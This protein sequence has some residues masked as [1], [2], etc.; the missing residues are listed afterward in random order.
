MF[1]EYLRGKG[2]YAI[3]ES[4]TRDEHAQSKSAVRTILRNPRYTGPE[5][6]KI[7]RTGPSQVWC[8]LDQS[9][10]GQPLRAVERHRR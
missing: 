3:A 1:R 5:V 2:L 8:P 10:A 4:L 9:R 7:H 6:S